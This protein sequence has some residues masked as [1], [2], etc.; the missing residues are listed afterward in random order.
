MKKIIYVIS[1]LNCFIFS[2]LFTNSPILLNA[3]PGWSEDYRLTY[4]PGY[5][6]NP[7]AVCNGDT[8]HLVW[9]EGYVDTIIHEEVFYKRSTDAG[10]TWGEDVRLTQEDSIS[11]VTPCIAVWGDKIHVVWKEQT[12]YYSA[13]CYRKSEDGGNT[14]G[15]I[16]TI[17]KSNI[18]GWYHPWISVHN[19]VI[20]CVTI[21]TDGRLVFVKSVDNGNSWLP[22][23]DIA[24]A[25]SQ[26]RVKNGRLDSL[27]LN[28]VY[29]HML[30]KNE[31]YNIRSFDSG[32]SWT[33]S[34]CISE[35][36]GISS[37]RPAM[38]TDDSGGVHI[39][40]Y[41]YKYSP[42]PWTGDIFYRASRDSGNTW[43]E[44]DSLT[45]MHRATWSDVLAEGNNLH[46]VWQDDRHGFDT[47]REIY[48]RMSRDLGQTWG[49][50][51]RLTDAPCHSFRP[52]LACD[53]NNLHLFWSDLRDDPS[54]RVGEIYYKCKDLS[55][56][57]E[58]SK[59]STCG[60]NL[61]FVVSPNPFARTFGIGLCSSKMNVAI[62]IFDVS[63]EEVMS[64]EMRDITKQVRIDAKHLPS[65]V[66][67]VEVEAGSERAIEKVV[68]V[69]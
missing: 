54:N 40:W 46:L 34:Q 53:G 44:I 18:D 2:S 14:W 5:S 42:N 36:D 37:Q 27:F 39:T 3:Q 59:E 24:A 1:F 21:K 11:A 25:S 12:A 7:R 33:D 35:Q 31:I 20:S 38:D 15:N 52:S 19:N 64:R 45:V 16:D 4:R 69:R 13:I 56:S 6:Y 65:G 55:Y 57:I 29:Q 23:Q 10:M 41:D 58:E 43:G 61:S 8:I 9:W 50:E 32:E 68:K 22:S 30:Y 66:Y 17:F 47:N 60:T 26:P 63:G 48:Y 51:V 28:V 62:K 49:P 67:F